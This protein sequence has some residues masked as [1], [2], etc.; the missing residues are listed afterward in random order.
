MISIFLDETW[1]GSN[2]KEKL[3]LEERRDSL[4][5]RR[6]QVIKGKDQEIMKWQEEH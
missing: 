2:V 5:A 3:T 1:M 6:R 4:R